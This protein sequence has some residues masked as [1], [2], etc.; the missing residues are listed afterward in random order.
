MN[1]LDCTLE[2]NVAQC[3]GTRIRLDDAVAAKGRRIQGKLELG[4]RPMHLK[5]SREALDGS[6][7]AQVKAVED[8]GSCR[9]VSV[10]LAGKTLRVRLPEGEPVPEDRAWLV[11]PP[12]WTRLFADGRLVK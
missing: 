2:G 7:P 4:I 5:L 8:Q 1:F 11:F 3:N 12:E 10:I 6:V 9:I